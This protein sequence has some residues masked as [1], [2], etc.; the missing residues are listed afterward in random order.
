MTLKIIS[1]VF[2]L[3]AVSHE[4]RA[5]EYKG[6]EHRDP[7]ESVAGQA[8]SETNETSSLI[9]DGIA[10]GPR[11]TQAV[12]SRQVVEVGSVVL[13]AKVT[14]INKNSVTLVYRGKEIILTEKGNS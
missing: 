10:R 6:S 11:G 5:I 9:L 3:V 14:A 1:I 8:G 2:F 12:I 7:F 13:G 4:A